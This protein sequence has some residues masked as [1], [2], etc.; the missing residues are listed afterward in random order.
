MDEKHGTLFKAKRLTNKGSFAVV[1]EDGVVR[2]TVAGLSDT[3]S[4]GGQQPFFVV[5]PE[6]EVLGY[7]VSVTWE[8]QGWGNQKGRVGISGL[9]DSFFSAHA[10]HELETWESSYTFPEPWPAAKP[11]E[12]FY[13]VGGGGGHQLTVKS[14]QLELF[15][16]ARYHAYVAA[17]EAVRG[18]P[19]SASTQS[20][21]PLPLDLVKSVVRGLAPK[22]PPPS[23]EGKL[24]PRMQPPPK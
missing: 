9:L 11:M 8:D 17:F 20:L 1:E 6:V 18:T 7:Q 4:R 19:G 3:R 12:I 24:A 22:L 5:T 2:V 14:M 16:A 23:P 15:T 13:A 21:L 10:P